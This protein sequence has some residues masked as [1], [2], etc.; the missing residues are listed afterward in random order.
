MEKFPDRPAVD[1][2][3]TQNNNSLIKFLSLKFILLSQFQPFSVFLGRNW[4]KVN[5]VKLIQLNVYKMDCKSCD[6]CY[7]GESGQDLNIQIKEHK[8]DVT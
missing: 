3:V 8:Y 1:G 6:K 7:V 5:F 2:Y 4:L